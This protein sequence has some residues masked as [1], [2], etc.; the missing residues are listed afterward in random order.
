MEHKRLPLPMTRPRLLA[1]LPLTPAYLRESEEE[2]GL[3]RGIATHKALSTLPLAPLR[4]SSREAKAARSGEDDE[5]RRQLEARLCRVIEKELLLLQTEGR[6]SDDECART[7]AGMLARFF[8][9]GIGQRMLA[10]KELHREWSFNL[11]A[12]DICESL[13]QGVIDL[14]FWEE[15]GWVLVDYKTDRVESAAELWPTY[16]PQMRVYQRALAKAT[17]FPVRE[18]VLFSLARGEGHSSI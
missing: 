1:D 12:P 5:A 6:M 14:C 15:N 2:R 16:G 7:D 11:R 17:G 13:L 4:E 9:S 3:L 18:A 10:A 8:A